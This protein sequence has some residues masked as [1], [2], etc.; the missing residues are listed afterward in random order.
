MSNDQSM[1]DKLQQAVA[2]LETLAAKA[3]QHKGRKSESERELADVKAMQALQLEELNSAK[4][5][6]N[7]LEADLAKLTSENKNLRDGNSLAADRL[8]KAIDQL[9]VLVAA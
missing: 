3:E 6:V 4:A 2:R 1:Q 7:K 5:M 9:K 8:D